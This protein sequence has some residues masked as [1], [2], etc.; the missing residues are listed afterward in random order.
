MNKKYTKKFQ[1][2]LKSEKSLKKLEKIKNFV[3]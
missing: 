1:I 2:F 3:Y